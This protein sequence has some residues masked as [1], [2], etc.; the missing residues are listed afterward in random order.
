MSGREY[1]HQSCRSL[2]LADFIILDIY[3][4]HMLLILERPIVAT[5]QALMDFEKSELILR[6]KEKQYSFTM[7]GPLKQPIDIE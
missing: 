4:Q 3:A 7:Y 6:V 1:A 5:T 2:Y